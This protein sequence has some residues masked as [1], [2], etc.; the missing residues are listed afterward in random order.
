MTRKRYL[1]WG[2]VRGAQRA[3]F[4][5]FLAR[6]VTHLYGP[7]SGAAAHGLQTS[8]GK[9]STATHVSNLSA[10]ATTAAEFRL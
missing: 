10:T 1:L 7:G 6:I 3:V 2:L 5:R 8:P 9:D 4:K